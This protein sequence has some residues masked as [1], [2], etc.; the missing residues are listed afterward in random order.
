MYA[1]VSLQCGGTF[2]NA[3][4]NTGILLEFTFVNDIFAAVCR[5]KSMKDRLIAIIRQK[6]MSVSQFA[7]AVGIQ[8]STFHHIIS[9]RN[10]P[11]L[12]VVSKIHTA[13]PDIDLDWLISGNSRTE[14]IQQELFPD[15]NPVFRPNDGGNAEYSNP[16]GGNKPAAQLSTFSEPTDSARRI[17]K[18]ITVYSDGT[19]ESFS[20]DC[21]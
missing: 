15:E 21:N 13:Y 10:N 19:T 4:N 20:P 2:V 18:I 17:T 14:S 3:H 5:M 6:Q 1:P 8:R 11:S 7:D 12:E 9:G 16:G